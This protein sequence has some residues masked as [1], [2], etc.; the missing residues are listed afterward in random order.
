MTDIINNAKANKK[1]TA[2]VATVGLVVGVAA[3][4]VAPKLIKWVNSKFPKKD[5][6]AKAVA[7]TASA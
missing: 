2:V 5:Q 7:A 6:A 1:A 3:A 4:I